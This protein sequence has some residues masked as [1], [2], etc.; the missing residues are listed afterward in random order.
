MSQ[1]S[2]ALRN[3]VRERARN[4]CEYC[5]LPEVFIVAHEPDHVI[6]M[7]HRG[8]TSTENLALACFDCNRRKGPNISSVDPETGEIVQ[9]FNP[10]R[11]AWLEHFR[12][13][14]VRIIGRT[15]VGRA[16]AEL[17]QFNQAARVR[18]REELHKA[19]RY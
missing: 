15:P 12:L 19:G 8:M 13:E 3:L 10:R 14:G 11:E 4:R 17:L 18:I 16:T 6:A 9:L 2:N 1:V 5:L 7:Q